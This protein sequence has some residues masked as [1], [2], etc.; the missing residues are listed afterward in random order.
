VHRFGSQIAVIGL[1]LLSARRQPNTIVISAK[2][3]GGGFAG[4]KLP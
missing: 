2:P 3:E 1:A 4:D